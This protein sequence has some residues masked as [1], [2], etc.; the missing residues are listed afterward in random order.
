MNRSLDL[1][2]FCK[3]ICMKHM[4]ACQTVH[5][6]TLPHAAFLLQLTISPSCLFKHARKESSNWAENVFL[7][8]QVQQLLS[9]AACHER[10][11]Q[12]TD[13]FCERTRPFCCR[14]SAFRA[15]SSS[16]APARLCVD[17]SSRSSSKHG[18]ISQE[19][20]S[21]FRTF[22]T[23]LTGKLT[24]CRSRSL[25]RSETKNAASSCDSSGREGVT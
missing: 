23:A 24:V 12:S 1:G 18:E 15:Q 6:E 9:S 20:A 19:S 13:V 25:A 5:G 4:H 21:S 10:T 2:L 8:N 16:S 17:M 22:Q 3:D 14:A 7:L 11:S